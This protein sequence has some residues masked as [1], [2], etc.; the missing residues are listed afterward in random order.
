MSILFYIIVGMSDIKMNLPLSNEFRRFFHDLSALAQNV[1]NLQGKRDGQFDIPDAPEG[2]LFAKIRE[3]SLPREALEN[4]FFR[5]LE[6]NDSHG[7]A[8]NSPV[9]DRLSESADNLIHDRGTIGHFAQSLQS[10][11]ELRDFIAAQFKEPTRYLAGLDS[12]SKSIIDQLE[13]SFKGQFPKVFTFLKTFLGLRNETN[14]TV[15][16]EKITRL[17]DVFTEKLP[18]TY[19]EKTDDEKLLEYNPDTQ[20]ITI[21]SKTPTLDDLGGLF[22]TVRLDSSSTE[23]E[24][25]TSPKYDRTDTVSLKDLVMAYEIDGRSAVNNLLFGPSAFAATRLSRTNEEAHSRIRED[26]LNILAS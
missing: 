13:D 8:D 22:Y 2:S 23:A 1:R 19:A 21:Q 11:R 16:S 6:T 17:H 15:D 18:F 20:T 5:S 10:L 3:L 14:I 25:K 24:S 9:M 12:L 26:I 4:T 7:L